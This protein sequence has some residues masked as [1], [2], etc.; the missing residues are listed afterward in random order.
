MYTTSVTGH[1]RAPRPAVYRALLDSGAVAT[2]RV[3]NGMTATVHEFDAREG[4]WFRVSLT[5]DDASEAG[6]SGG[7]TD[8]YRGR[9]TLLVPDE[10][11]VEVSTFETPD[12]TLANEMTMTT[13]LVDAGDGTDVTILH[14]GI[15]DDIPA[16][17]NEA[18]TR[19]ALANLARLVEGG[20]S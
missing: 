10:R 20:T 18:G 19:M 11:V 3:P 8:T 1:V 6:K 14:E 15:P 9:F 17:D 12:P 13:T 4:G 7:H 2:W 16:A 5:Y